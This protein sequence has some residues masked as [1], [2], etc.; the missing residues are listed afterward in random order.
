MRDGS[1]A[2]R[3]IRP[4]KART[5]ISHPLRID[6]LTVGSAGGLIGIT[7]CPGKM[8]PS[9]SGFE[10]RRDLDA[11]LAVVA[12]WRATAVVTLLENQE[13]QM[14]GVE[15][16]GQA[17]IALGMQWHHLPI[18]D[19]D[20]PDERFESAWKSVGPTL[21]DLLKAGRRVLVHCR[22]GLGRAGTVGAR[23]LIDMGEQPQAAIHRIRD[24]RAGAIETL[25]QV[26]YLIDRVRRPVEAPRPV[27]RTAQARPT[28]SWFRD[29]A[30]FGEVAGPGG[31]DLTQSRFVVEGDRLRSLVNDRTFGIGRLELLSVGDLRQR[32]NANPCVAGPRRARTV[33]GDAGQLHA[34]RENHG[35]LFQVASQFNLLE[36][37]GPGVTPEAGVSGYANDNTQGPACAIAAGAATI[38]R[39]YFAPVRGQIGQRSHRQL[40]GLASLASALARRPDAPMQA[41]WSMKNGYAMFEPASVDRLS[42]HLAELNERELTALRHLLR[43]GVQWGV[44]VTSPAAEAGQQ[45]T[46]AFCSALPIGYHH[47]PQHMAANWEP[48]ARLVLDALYE[49]TL[50]AAVVNAQSGGSTTALLTFVGGGVFQNKLAWIRAAIER[51]VRAVAGHDLDIAVVYFQAPSADDLA[52]VEGLGRIDQAPA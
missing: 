12:D 18:K 42:Q 36:M 8:G 48:L 24:T 9:D 38:Y 37:T 47:G 13:F 10:W 50:W 32:A 46:Q 43:I 28:P 4:I 21:V 27:A 35:A 7:F 2:P 6:A 5:S 26:Q 22:G 1:Q 31:Y 45:V 16:L 51:A 3:D 39:N 20:T 19:V 49:A 41:L 44:Q 40:D 23:L 33:R 15:R 34:V 11:D 14:F 30:G 29:L 17:V 25:D 52:W